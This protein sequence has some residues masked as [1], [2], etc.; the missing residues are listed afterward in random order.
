ML[1]KPIAAY[2]SIVVKEK[3]RLRY[4]TKDLGRFFNSIEYLTLETIIAQADPFS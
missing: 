2:Y 4:D 3:K 1:D